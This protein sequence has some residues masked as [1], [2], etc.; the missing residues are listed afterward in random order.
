MCDRELNAYCST[1]DDPIIDD[2]TD[3]TTSTTTLTSAK[4][5]TNATNAAVATADGPTIGFR[6]S[7][8]LSAPAPPVI[9]VGLMI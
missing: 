4:T 6:N 7:D 1:V 9:K 5:T 3:V 2:S 8:A